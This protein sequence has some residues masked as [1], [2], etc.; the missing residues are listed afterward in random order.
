VTKRK[1]TKKSEAR[2]RELIEAASSAR[3]AGRLEEAERLYREAAGLKPV[4][5]EALFFLGHFLAH[6]GRPQEAIAYLRRGARLAPDVPEICLELG[7]A[8]EDMGDLRK[9]E[10]HF[11]EASRLAPMLM[12][13]PLCLGNLYTRQSRHQE[14]ATAYRHAL[15]LQ[16]NDPGT[17]LNLGHSLNCLGLMEE[18]ARHYEAAA[19]AEP[20]FSAAHGSLAQLAQSSGRFE[21]ALTHY[22]HGIDANPDDP[23]IH[24][25]IATAYR[26]LG[27]VDE[28]A[29]HFRRADA[30]SPNPVSRAALASLLERAHRLDDA[31]EAAEETLALDPRSAEARLVL[32]KIARRLEGDP[33]AAPLYEALIA[34]CQQGELHF[35]PAVLARAQAD[36]AGLREAGGDTNAALKLYREANE[37]NCA[38]FPAWAEETRNYISRVHALTQAVRALPAGPVRTTDNRKPKE[39]VFLVGFPRSGTTLLDQLLNAH[40]TIAVMEEKPILD[41]VSEALGSAEA[42]RPQAVLEGSAAKLEPLRR[43]YF[44]E[45][46]KY[47]PDRGPDSILVDKL[48]LNILNLWLAAALFPGAKVILALRDPRDVCLSCFTNLFRLGPGL[49]GFPSLEASADLYAAVMTLWLESRQRLDL[50]FHIVRYEDLIDD[51]EREARRL[52][53]FLELDW[54]DQVLGYRELA[55]KRYIV[56]PSYHQ[57]VRPLYGSARGRWRRFE[58]ALAPVTPTLRPFLEAF[59]YDP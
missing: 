19:R 3:A 39:P 36:L 47:C 32:A 13:A 1:D 50:S 2:C 26:D 20:T 14:A 49:A 11:R 53:A 7:L 25:G 44:D 45:A 38:T 31:R 17:L 42:S 8:Y 40:P 21:K 28:A 10:T 5:S 52:V 27:R 9:A 41:R 58:S 35:S 51:L 33:A 23:S 30:L 37:T 59:G 55:R 24:H 6:T 4:R 54:K 12:D 29:S 46:E 48:P 56:T 57:V 22:R 15:D 43:L 34:G 16:P 18:A